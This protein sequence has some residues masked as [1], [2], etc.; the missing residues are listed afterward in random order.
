M[1]T[2]L[3]I[4]SIC[5]WL[6]VL[7]V[8]AQDELPA[9]RPSDWT[10]FVTIPKNIVDVPDDPAGGLLV[11]GAFVSTRSSCQEGEVNV[12][13][14]PESVCFVQPGNDPRRP[15]PMQF[16]YEPRVLTI[17]EKRMTHC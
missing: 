5:L 10:C 15:D 6:F 7:P 4:R 3:R 13:V 11:F 9:N 16:T 14:Y 1:A 2:G 17:R 12:G 8:W